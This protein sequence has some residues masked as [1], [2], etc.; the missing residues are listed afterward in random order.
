MILLGGGPTDT[1]G[2]PIAL[3]LDS[4]AEDTTAIDVTGGG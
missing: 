1:G 4:A 3:K 2:R